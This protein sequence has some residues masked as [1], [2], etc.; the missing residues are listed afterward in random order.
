MQTTINLNAGSLGDGD[1]LANTGEV[2][3][4]VRGDFRSIYITLD[5]GARR[6]TVKP[7][8]RFDIIR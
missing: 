4:D 3:T 1:I 2:M 5:N 8:D 7:S 6:L